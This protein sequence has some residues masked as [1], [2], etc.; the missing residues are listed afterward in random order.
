MAPTAAIRRGSFCNESSVWLG[1]V[2]IFFSD[3][4]VAGLPAIRT[5]IQ[6]IHAKANTVLRLAETTI[7]LAGAFCLGLIA[8]QADGGHLNDLLL[9]LT[10]PIHSILGQDATRY[11]RVCRWLL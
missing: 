6:S 2:D 11:K 3:A 1:S 8:L 5:I 4:D 9:Q 10:G 7:L